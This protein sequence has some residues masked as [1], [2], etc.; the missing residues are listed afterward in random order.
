MVPAINLMPWRWS[1]RRR[2]AKRFLC[3]LSGSLLAALLISATQV[4]VVYFEH[5]LEGKNLSWLQAEADLLEQRLVIQQEDHDRLLKMVTRIERLDQLKSQGKQ[6]VGLLELL[7]QGLPPQ[8]AYTHL[9]RSGT[10][11]TLGG[12]AS[13]SESVTKLLRHL[14]QSDWFSEAVLERLHDQKGEGH[15]YFTIRLLERSP[16]SQI[17]DENSP[18]S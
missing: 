3:W 17:E 14:N 2:R 8:L 12:V 13:S 18:N 4:A 7:S 11:V 5:R 15:F 16:V 1:A 9:S 10:K 6:M